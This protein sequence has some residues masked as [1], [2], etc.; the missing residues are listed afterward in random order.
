MIMLMKILRFFRPRKLDLGMLNMFIAQLYRLTGKAVGIQLTSGT[1]LAVCLSAVQMA[2]GFTNKAG[3]TGFIWALIFLVGIV[4]AVLV[5]RFSLGGLQAVSHSMERKTALIDQFEAAQKAKQ[6]PATKEEKKEL[7]KAKKRE[8]VNIW[9][10]WFISICGIF[11]SVVLGDEFWRLIFKNTPTTISS[12]DTFLS[13]I[14][15]WLC[16]SVVSGTLMQ[17]E[18]CKALNL[19]SL[20][21][22]ITDL[23][24]P[25][26]A[27]AVEGQ[28][29]ELDMLA[30]SYKAVRQDKAARGAAETKIKK[31]LTRRMT[32]FADQID[33]IV[34]QAQSMNGMLPGTTVDA[35]PPNLPAIGHRPLALPD[36]RK[37][38]KYPLYRDELIRLLRTDPGKSEREVAKHFGVSASTAGT[39][40]KWIREGK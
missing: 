12:F 4:M 29:L 39:W 3:Q 30:D 38:G 11:L 15:P 7:G 9:V 26:L 16:A 1:F 8:W 20:A 37:K 2:V 21:A 22:I 5:E 32:D 19:R 18:L 27:V 33:T 25:R 35:L 28:Q 34:D 31:T 23:H 24:L 10:G 6:E 13:F 40:M 17:A 36:P 14:L